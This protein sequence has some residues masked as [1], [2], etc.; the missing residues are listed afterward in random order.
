M[1]EGLQCGDL[2]R[3]DRLLGSASDAV[4]QE[5][6]EKLR[7]GDFYERISPGAR[8]ALAREER[9]AGVKLLS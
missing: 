6:L 7:S 5:F 3:L 9:V 8:G 4:L 1:G 2:R